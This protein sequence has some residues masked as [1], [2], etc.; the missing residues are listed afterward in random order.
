VWLFARTNAVCADR[1]RGIIGN[2][3]SVLTV[4]DINAAGI[5]L[6]NAQGREG[7]VKWD[8]LRDAAG[9]RIGLSYGDVLT[10]DAA[11][12]LTSTEHIQAMPGGTQAVTGY[13]AYTAANHH[14]VA[15]YIV[16]SD[17]AERRE[18]AARRPLDQAVT[19]AGPWE[20]VRVSRAKPTTRT[21]VLG[22]RALPR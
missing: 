9:G 3:G 13:K 17:G 14:R 15:S 1:S 16:T 8:T 10:I 2:N 12:G 19:W 18:I 4:R 21:V 22:T 6:E 7:L 5:T 20:V 11:Q